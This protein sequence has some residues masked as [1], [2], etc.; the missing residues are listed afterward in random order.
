M[1]TKYYY[2][3]LRSQ[4]DF[5]LRYYQYM[6]KDLT[7]SDL[8]VS[9]IDEVPDLINRICKDDIEISSFDK[10]AMRVETNLGTFHV[11]TIEESRFVTFF[12][13]DMFASDL[14]EFDEPDWRNV[15]EFD[16]PENIKTT[17]IHFT[18]NDQEYYSF[19]YIGD[20]SLKRENSMLL[21]DLHE[22]KRS[23]ETKQEIRSFKDPDMFVLEIGNPKSDDMNM[24][25]KKENSYDV[26]FRF[27]DCDD[28]VSC[29]D[30]NTFQ[31]DLQVRKVLCVS[32]AGDCFCWIF[33]SA[34]SDLRE[35]A[36]KLRQLHDEGRNF[37][38]EQLYAMDK[39]LNVHELLSNT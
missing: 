34:Q 36:K 27:A 28:D 9:S 18:N 8:L 38:A 22:T 33:G 25:W 4:H 2:V 39:N 11:L 12:D 29:D 17:H 16:V 1:N 21:Q 19:I 32:P 3:Q 31:I 24:A 7:A 15:V 5:Y 30:N 23:N 10:S 13:E 14:D 6:K 37:D 26:L 20:E 35:V